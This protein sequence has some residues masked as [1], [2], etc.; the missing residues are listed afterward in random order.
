[1][2]EILIPKERFIEYMRKNHDSWYAFAREKDCILNPEDVF[3]VRGWVKSS[4]WAVAAFMGGDH[5]QEIQFVAQAGSLTLLSISLAFSSATSVSCQHRVHTPK[6]GLDSANGEQTHNQCLFLSRY[7]IHR[8]YMLP[9][10]IEAA[11]G[12][13]DKDDHDSDDSVNDTHALAMPSTSQSE[14][15]IED[16]MP[17]TQV[18]SH[19]NWCSTFDKD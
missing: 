9:N 5:T 12:N 3:M 10:K 16:D 14:T 6:I 8:R 15:T 19:I 4:A 1:M 7:K 18:I 2:Q 11:A 13:Q 17:E